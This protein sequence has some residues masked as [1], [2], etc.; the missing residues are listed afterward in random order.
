[1]LPEL[2]KNI[3]AKQEHAVFDR[4]NLVSLADYSVVY[5]VLYFINIAD[6]KIFLTIQ[7]NIYLE[8]LQAFEDNGIDFAFPGQTFI[9]QHPVEANKNKS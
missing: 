2:I 3:V 4:C 6:Y 9:L 8:I 7:Q 5:E 1:M